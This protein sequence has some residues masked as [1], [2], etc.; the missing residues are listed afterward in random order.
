LRKSWAS[1]FAAKLIASALSLGAIAS[2]PVPIRAAPGEQRFAIDIPAGPIAQSL[3]TFAQQSGTSLGIEGRLPDVRTPAVKGRLTPREA[4]DRLL[5]ETPIEAVTAGPSSFRLQPRRQEQRADHAL[6]T[7]SETM[8]GQEIVVTA[9]RRPQPLFGTPLSIAVVPGDLGNLGPG[10]L[11]GTQAMASLV[12]GLALTNLGSGR[13]RIFLRSVADSPFN[14]YSQSTVSVMLDDTRVT[15]DAPDPDLRLVDVDRVELL[16]GPQGPLYGTGALGGVYR[17]VTNKPDLSDPAAAIAANGVAADALG[18][19]IDAMLNLPLR[20]DRLGLRVSGYAQ[21]SPG[22][23]D[24]ADGRNDSNREHVA[25]GRAALRWAPAAGWTVDLATTLQFLTVDDS[26]YL[27]A[28]A[29][30]FL[31]PNTIAEPHDNDVR[32]VSGAA[33]GPLGDMRLSLTAST[34]WHE[35]RSTLDA[36]ASASLLGVPAPAVFVDDRNY[37]VEDEEIRLSSAEVSAIGWVAGL[38]RLASRSDI[39]GDLSGSGAPPTR[40][41]SL[42]R[43]VTELAAYGSVSLRLASRWSVDVGARLAST[44]TEDEASEAVGP[45]TRASGSEQRITPSAALRW[46]P[47]AGA[48]LFLR[49]GQGGRAS[50]LAPNIGSVAQ[51]F[52]AD[53]L[54]SFELG[55]QL[56]ADASLEASASLYRMHWYD[57]QSDYLL[58]NGLISTHNAGDANITGIEASLRWHPLRSWSIDAGGT[59]QRGRLDEPAPGAV[60]SDDPRLPVVPDVFARATIGRAVRLGSWHGEVEALGR[61]VGPSRLSF[62][63]GLD[64]RQPGYAT[65]AGSAWLAKGRWRVTLTAENLFDGHP[66]TFAFGNPFSIRVEPQS[67]PLAPRRLTLG[68]RFMVP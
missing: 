33:S 24:N 25:G 54:D 48:T 23:I 37:T 44:T 42:A 27:A 15:F 22:W 18:G 63:A 17:L 2:V 30:L 58:P 67:T 3:A 53:R 68:V 52:R 14:G 59:L 7:S 62:D 56:R 55:A 45:A 21:S 47:S 28:G 12:D 49:Y 57:L 4:L 34:T 6:P 36:S 29:P 19:G 46:T 66:D 26:Q 61:Y 10:P 20:T 51:P 35:V 65:L 32:I 50:G 1:T 31:R 43:R 5:R 40:I 8:L 11:S 38:S 64:R 39:A 60:T 13:N 41:V 16:K 9:G